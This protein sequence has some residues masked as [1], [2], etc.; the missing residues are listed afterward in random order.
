MIGSY[1][2]RSIFHRVIAKTEFRFRKSFDE[3]GAYSYDTKVFLP[4]QKGWAWVQI[5]LHQKLLNSEIVCHLRR[6]SKFCK[7][8]RKCLNMA[9]SQVQ[10]VS[11]LLLALAKPII[12]FFFLHMAFLRGV[13]AILATLKHC[14]Q[15]ADF[16][17]FSYC[18]IFPPVS[19][20]SYPRFLLHSYHNLLYSSIGWLSRLNY[21]PLRTI[22]LPH[23]VLEI[24]VGHRPISEQSCYL[25]DHFLVC[26]VTRPTSK[27]ACSIQP[28]FG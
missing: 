21:A 6:P 26:S 28:I 18:Y 16:K 12:N 4:G 5:L 3:A 19:A 17:N 22:N 27:I 13:V 10:W 7:K 25:T 23:A 1:I 14:M 11:Q 20:L 8:S 9:N 15:N 2:V 24:T